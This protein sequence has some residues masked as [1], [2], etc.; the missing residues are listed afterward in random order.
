M[1]DLIDLIETYGRDYM[2]RQTRL[3]LNKDGEQAIGLSLGYKGN[4]FSSG[5]WFRMSIFEKLDTDHFESDDGV[6]IYFPAKSGIYA[7][8]SNVTVA[9]AEIDIICEAEP[10]MKIVLENCMIHDDFINSGFVIKDCLI[11]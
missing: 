5:V 6:K 3:T 8:L 2:G 7:G 11:V 4:G 9:Y 1:I 10:K